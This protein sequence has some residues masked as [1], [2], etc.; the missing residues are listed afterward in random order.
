M[1]HCKSPPPPSALSSPEKRP[2]R[3]EPKE[4]QTEKESMRKQTSKWKHSPRYVRK[5]ET[6]TSLRCQP[7]WVHRRREKH[8][9][10]MK[11]GGRNRRW[12]GKREKYEGRLAAAV[13]SPVDMRGGDGRSREREEIG[14][15]GEEDGGLGNEEEGTKQRKVGVRPSPLLPPPFPSPAS[16]GWRKWDSNG[17]VWKEGGRSREMEGE[18]GVRYLK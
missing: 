10:E 13:A 6:F 4:N 11:L 9:R 14:W 7:P 15:E 12:K 1:L 17:W 5:V 2:P 3:Y 16:Q 18:K 8:W